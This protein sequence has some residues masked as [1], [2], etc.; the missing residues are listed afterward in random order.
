MTARFLGPSGKGLLYLL[1]VWLSICAQLASLGLGEASIYFIGKDRNRLPVI[2]SNLLITTSLLGVVLVGAGWLVLQYSRP[3][4]Y[5]QFPLW[6]WGIVAFLVPL[7]LLQSFL[8]QVLSAILRIKEINL[9]EITKVI[10][11]LLLFVL[12]VII[13]GQGI[14]GAF[15]AYA[16]S[17]FFAA[18]ALFLLVLSHGERLK[19][20]SWTQFAALLRYGVKAYLCSLLGLLTLRLDALL[21]ASLAVNGIHDAG[22]YSV[23]TNLAELVLFIPASI[24][25]SLFPMVSACGV[26]EAN[27]LTPM[28][29]R[30]TMLLTIILGLGLATFGEYGISQIY[31]EPFHGALIPLLLLMPGVIM[32]S[33][34]IIF[35]GDLHGRGKPGATVVSTLSSL[36][37]ILILDF[38][39]IPRYGITGAAIASSCAYGTEFFIVGSFFVYYSGIGWRK[40][41]FFQRAD[42]TSYMKV[43]PVFRKLVRLTN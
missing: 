41:Y 3:D 37:M 25:L 20:P 12:L 22:V 39:L 40:L 10:A 36:T 27:R 17:N 28:A 8:T 19:R 2:V 16:A 31:G 42:F 14:K 5:D 4:I 6:I 11:Q 23:A 21:V 35:Y 13:M 30:H 43:L 7:H 32:W 26:A 24:R 33:Q 29:C 18:S 38:V 9:I 34:A 1:I 15:L